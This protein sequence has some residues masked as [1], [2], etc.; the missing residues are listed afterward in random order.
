MY[1]MQKYTVTDTMHKLTFKFARDIFHN[2][3]PE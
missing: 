2:V 1:V 3:V